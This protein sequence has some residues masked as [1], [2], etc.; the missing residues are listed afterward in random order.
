M[1]KLL[2]FLI[3]I[4]CSLSVSAVERRLDLR[5]QPT[6]GRTKLATPEDLGVLRR[7]NLAAGLTTLPELNVGDRL[8]V[9]LFD[10]V[11]LTVVL[12]E[13]LESPLAGESF[14][15][16]VDGYDGLKN[17]CVLQTAEGLQIDVQDTKNG[18][19]YTVVSSASGTIVRE[20]DPGAGT[21][22]PCEP[23]VPELDGEVEIDA[24]KGRL[25][26]AAAAE[27][28]STLVDVLVAYDANAAAWVRTNGG[29]LEAFA[30]MAVAKMNTAMANNAL[31]AN[32]RFRLV[33]TT[34]AAVQANDVHDALT[35]LHDNQTGWDA[36]KAKREE[37]GADIV[38]TLIDTGSAYGTTGVGWS[39]SDA[40]RIAS[41]ANSAYN[42][43][44]IRA[45]AQ[46]HTMTHEV[47]HNM[48]AG[49]ATAVDPAQISPGPQLYGYSAGYYFTANGTAYHTIMAY[50][51]D[52][53]GNNY[54]AA[55][56]F[57]SP[58]RKWDGIAAGDETH[59]N[60]KTLRNTYA[61]ASNWRAQKIAMSYDVFF[62]PETETL[63][64]DSV[65]VTLT[66][67]KAGLPI[68]YTTDGSTPTL[69]SKLYSSSF[70]LK[71]TTT[72][73]A[74]T[75]TDGKLGPVFE[76][77][78]LKSDLGTAL[79]APELNWTTGADYPWSTQT[80]NTTDGFAA[81]SCPDFVGNYGCRKTSWLKT[82]VTGPADLSFRY[83]KRMY[84]SA[85]RVYSD[86]REIWS[87]TVGGSTISNGSDW[88]V[89]MIPIPVGTHEI[90]FSFEQGGGYY[91]G[92]N[93]IVLDDIGLD[94][95][96]CPPTI[97]PTTTDA[98]STAMTFRGEMT[99][100]LTP[101]EG[102]SGTI[103]YT[104]DGS[105]PTGSL[106]TLYTGPFK[107]TK[108]VLVK[109]IFVTPGREASPLVK[110][111][112]LERHP[113]EPGEWTTDV[114]GAKTAAAKNGKLIAVLCAN[115]AGCGW[116]QRFTPFSESPEF[117]LWA[118]ANG[119]YLI[120]SDTYGHV[121]TDA[122]DAYFWKLWNAG[123]VGYPSIAFAKPSAPDVCVATG[124]ARNSPSYTVAGVPFTDTVESLIKGFAAAMGVSSVPSAPTISPDQ[125]YV[126]KLPMT[127][128]LTNPNGSGTIY[129]TLDGTNPATSATRKAY[130][131]AIT[132]SDKTAV[133]TAIVR[134]SAG[135]YSVP[136]VRRF[137]LYSD[138]VNGYFGTSDIVW[139]K[140][141][142]V[143][144]QE[145]NLDGIK[146][147]LRTGGYLNEM[148]YTS[149]LSAK[150]TGKGKF[151]FSYRF[152][153][154]NASN[155]MQYR[156]NGTV[157]K[158]IARFVG[159]DYVIETVELDLDGATTVDWTYDVKQW[160]ADYT[161]GY[162]SGG[163]SAW[164]GLWLYDVAWLPEKKETTTTT[165]VPVPYAWIAARFPSAGEATYETLMKADSDGDGYTNWEEYLCGTDPNVAAQTTD[166]VP[167]CTIRIVNGRPEVT[168]NVVLPDGAKALGWTVTKFGST[169]LK[170]WQT[171]RDGSEDD[172]RFFKVKVSQ[173]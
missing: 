142:T 58:N 107:I 141:G 6:A 125:D 139:T 132:V 131:G 105:D 156:V 110:G 91:G 25:V 1:H 98:Q 47:G 82:A 116:T 8:E 79:N 111:Y 103:Y 122:A 146:T 151:R 10:D 159:T 77:R 161:S 163:K 84:S 129:Y 153:N 126:D 46:G 157:K 140:T 38:T 108:S 30:Q 33:G 162:S 53:Y 73:K 168:H 115:Q 61:A 76:A 89:A 15:A 114:E 158:S 113:V 64:T 104:I 74:A 20:I 62:S 65:T 67:G 147:A 26:L 87:D 85:F 57:S 42:V 109:A 167:R 39:L 69:S 165:P 119:V 44:A 95:L 130:S 118:A 136:L 97:S 23:L 137:A 166:G 66:P 16:T 3:V 112:F 128:T 152:C 90:K 133:L 9:T 99:V 29:G 106:A 171:V 4:A 83:Q 173:Q 135:V 134:D 94:K 48:G 7:T 138:Y 55:P 60:E 36:I 24:P 155:T 102:Y 17:A 51:F 88:N 100:T 41:F 144:W 164:C 81:Q 117:L 2:M 120:T 86:N 96:S 124:T 148:T 12:A 92:F 54:T 19:V 59:D 170:T 149:T 150:I 56:L 28:S 45:V 49:H 14:L 160:S 40:S 123:S 70:V 143:G 34:E 50:N 31:D 32:F 11:E 127:V 37:V 101:P 75:V 154:W 71:A 63:F 52:G 13:R 145:H 78:Y 93:G 18:R 43:C 121:D 21:V 172:Y 35:A 80:A 5:A 72:V 27:Q 169:D 68:R 22:E